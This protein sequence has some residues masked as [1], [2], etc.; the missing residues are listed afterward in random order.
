MDEQL[1]IKFIPEGEPYDFVGV[2]KLV[3]GD[4]LIAG[5]TYPPEDDSVIMLHN[6]MQVLEAS[7]SDRSTMIKGFKLDLWMK[8]CMSLDE[9]FVIERARMITITTA[10]KPIRDFY[11]ENID[12]VFRNSIPNRVRPTPEMGSLGSINKARNVFEKLFKA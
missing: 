2:I 5:V 9:T 6:P 7:T 1:E 12:M 8:S 3:T 11:L 10:P 4:E